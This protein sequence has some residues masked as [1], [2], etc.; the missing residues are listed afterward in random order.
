MWRARSM[1]RAKTVADTAAMATPKPARRLPISTWAGVSGTTASS[2][3]SNQRSK[4]SFSFPSVAVSLV[5][6]MAASHV[7]RPCHP[8]NPNDSP[9]HRRGGRAVG[10][11]CA[12]LAQIEPPAGSGPHLMI[13]GAMTLS[14]A[15]GLMAASCG[16]DGGAGTTCGNG[17]VCG[18]DGGL[19]SNDGGP[20][21]TCGSV[22]P[23]GGDVVGD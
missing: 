23:C 22:Q 14:F 10:P 15:A 16:G 2:P 21:A 17:K 11:S 9:G 13:R 19:D 5:V 12:A 6:R 8:P 7:Q 1:T 18:G 4:K 20:A 3:C